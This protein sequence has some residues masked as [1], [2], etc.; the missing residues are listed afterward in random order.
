M[1]FNDDPR[2]YL[3]IGALTIL[4]HL[5]D[6]I[7][8][9]CLRDNADENAIRALRITFVMANKLMLLYITWGTWASLILTAVIFFNQMFFIM[10]N[11]M[12]V[13]VVLL[14]CTNSI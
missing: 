5:L 13:V 4:P 11:A 9:R 1:L 7:K 12:Y 6:E 8:K 10:V 3:V 2:M 14:E